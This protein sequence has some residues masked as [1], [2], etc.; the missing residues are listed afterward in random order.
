MSGTG[1]ECVG[2]MLNPPHPRELVREG[3]APAGL[4]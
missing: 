1:G 4:A 2:A 3:M